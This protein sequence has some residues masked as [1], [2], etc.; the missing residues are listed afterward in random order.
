MAR[1]VPRL[2][3]PLE[4]TKRWTNMSNDK[5]HQQVQKR[6]ANDF[7]SSV[8]SL[9]QFHC[10]GSAQHRQCSPPPKP[11]RNV[12]RR[13]VQ[14]HC[15]TLRLLAPKQKAC[16]HPAPVEPSRADSGQAPTRDRSSHRQSWSGNQ[17]NWRFLRNGQK[18]GRSVS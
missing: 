18:M 12:V 8:E 9:E 4:A 6:P 10:N 13:H 1:A 14:L 7:P 15:W 17:E 5:V 16:R 3:G 2:E 11:R